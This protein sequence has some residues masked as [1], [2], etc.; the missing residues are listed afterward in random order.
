MFRVRWSNRALAQ[1]AELWNQAS[2]PDRWSITQA[3][4]EAELRLRRNAPTEGESRPR[5][6]RLLFVPPLGITFRVEPDGQT[7]SV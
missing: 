2:Q 3:N 1:L 5:G 7:V 6:G 4:H